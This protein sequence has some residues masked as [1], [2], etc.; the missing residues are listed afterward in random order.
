MCFEGINVQVVGKVEKMNEKDEQTLKK[1][2]KR[3]K[4]K[5]TTTKQRTQRPTLPKKKKEVDSFFFGEGEGGL[6]FFD[7]PGGPSRI[8]TPRKESP[9]SGEYRYFSVVLGI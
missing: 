7:S 9:G 5:R 4:N 3:T 8:V 6:A 2:K 1:N